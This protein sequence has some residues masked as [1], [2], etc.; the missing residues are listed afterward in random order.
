MP[1]IDVIILTPSTTQ[2][3]PFINSLLHSIANSW[4]TNIPPTLS[5]RNN[6]KLT[7]HFTVRRNGTVEGNTVTV[8]EGSGEKDLDEAAIKAVRSAAPFRKF[9]KGFT[10]TSIE[11]QVRP[12]FWEVLSKLFDDRAIYGRA[13]H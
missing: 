7:L 3:G 10:R 1:S 2:F 8:Y 5:F 4:V 9:P 11:V 12:Q 13:P 6:E